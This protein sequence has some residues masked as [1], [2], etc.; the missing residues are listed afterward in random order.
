MLTN[1]LQI[2]HIT[3]SDFFKLNYFTVINKYGKAAV[4]QI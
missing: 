4:A 1:S 3:K 2:F